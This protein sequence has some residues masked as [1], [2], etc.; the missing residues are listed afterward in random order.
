[1]RTFPILIFAALLQSGPTALA[2]DAILF[3]AKVNRRDYVGGTITSTR[4]R[5]AFIDLGYEHGVVKGNKFWVF[6][7]IGGDYRRVGLLEITLVKRKMAIGITRRILPR[8]RD[9]VVIS[10]ADLNLWRG[11]TTD[12]AKRLRRMLAERERR[13]YDTN[14]TRVDR[15]DLLE[16]RPR[17]VMKLKTWRSRLAEL[18]PSGSVFWETT[19]LRRRRQDFVVSTDFGGLEIRSG[20]PPMLTLEAFADVLGR[21]QESV[22][23]PDT[24]LDV[25]ADDDSLANGESEQEEASKPSDSQAEAAEDPKAVLIAEKIAEIV[26]GRKQTK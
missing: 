25:A 19:G 2:A 11:R 17:N 20:K 14:D 5:T 9:S 26:K 13:G 1:M 16:E 15:E 21:V 22:A 12:E 10:A 3:D 18:K 24:P 23:A 7:K 6:R 8:R 4:G